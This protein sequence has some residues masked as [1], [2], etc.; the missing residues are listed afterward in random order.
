MS[1]WRIEYNDKILNDLAKLDRPVRRQIIDRFEWFVDRFDDVTPSPLHG[2]WKG[3]FKFRVGDWRIVYDF[4][5]S[6]RLIRVYQVD[7]RDKVYRQSG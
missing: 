5:S 1:G 4:D 3:F 7:R 2:D 6:R